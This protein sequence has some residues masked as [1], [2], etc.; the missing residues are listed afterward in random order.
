MEWEQVVW[1]MGQEQP[2][3]KGLVGAWMGV[4]GSERGGSREPDGGGRKGWE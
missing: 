4:K 3:S 1:E 2:W